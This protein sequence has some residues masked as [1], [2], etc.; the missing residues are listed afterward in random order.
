[1]C[2]LGAVIPLHIPHLHAGHGDTLNPC[3]LKET[4]TQETQE[5][6]L[7]VPLTKS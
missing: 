4:S 2:A 7:T 6:D 3:S 5:K 1:M